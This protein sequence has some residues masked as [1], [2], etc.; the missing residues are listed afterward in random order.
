MEANLKIARQS[1]IIFFLTLKV[2]ISF[3]FYSPGL[4]VI[5]SILECP[6]L[7]CPK[8]LSHQAKNWFNWLFLY[9]RAGLSILLAIYG[10]GFGRP[11][12][13]LKYVSSFSFKTSFY[14]VRCG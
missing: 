2:S 11:G 3:F 12:A 8:F 1:P 7:E 6:Y 10:I 5:N 13:V 4:Y 14:T 9:K